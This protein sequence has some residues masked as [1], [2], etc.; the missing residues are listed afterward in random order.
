[1]DYGSERFQYYVQTR[2]NYSLTLDTCCLPSHHAISKR[3]RGI[4]R[5]RRVAPTKAVS[6]SRHESASS[7]SFLSVVCR[8]NTIGRVEAF[9]EVKFCCLQFRRKIKDLVSPV[10]LVVIPCSRRLQYFYISCHII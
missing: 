3:S 4:S 1:M 10:N 6:T 2:R 9:V 5:P 8:R 7:A